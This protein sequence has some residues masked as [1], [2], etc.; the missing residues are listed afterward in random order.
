MSHIHTSTLAC[1]LTLLCEVIP[2]VRSSA[3]TWL[4]PGGYAE[5]PDARQGRAAI[6][7]ELLL[8]GAGDHDSRAHADALD[9]LGAS[10]S[11]VAGTYFMTLGATMLGENLSAA[12]PLFVDMVRRPRM[13]ADAVEPSRD[14]ALQALASL[15]DDPQ[16]RAVLAARARHF[17]MP[18]NRSGLGTEEGLSTITHEELVSGWDE[19]ARPGRSIFAVAGAIDPDRVAADLD[20]LLRDWDGSTPEPPLQGAPP[21]GYAHAV[22]ATNQVQIVL[23]H[24]APPETDERRSWLERVA[25]SVLSGGMSGRLFTEVRE[26]RGLCYSVSAGYRGDRTFGGVTAYVGTTPE[27]AQDSLN[28]LVEQLLHLHTDAGAI[29]RDEFDRAVIG[30]KSRL[31]FSGEST[32]ARSAALASDYFRLGRGRSLREMAEQI[33]RITLDDVNAYVASRALGRVTIQTLGPAPLTPPGAC[34]LTAG[35]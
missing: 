1:G 15:K 10:R 27:R 31:V 17:P 5:D 2:G 13:E 34:D 23:L 20:E 12:L 9:R 14:L 22:D 8:R 19:V 3:F 16:E 32:G 4:V 18:I 11:V 26:K 24:D 35:A 6:W 25:V 33:D 28:V 7:Q 21:R 29:T 30:M